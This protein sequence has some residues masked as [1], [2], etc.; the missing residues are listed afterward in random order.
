VGGGPIP[1]YDQPPKP[2]KVTKPRYPAEALAYKVEGTVVVEILIDTEGRVHFRRIV[3]SVP[4]LDVAAAETVEQW[5]FSPAIKNGSPVASVAHAPVGFHLPSS[6]PDPP[7]KAPSPSPAASSPEPLKARMQTSALWFDPEGADFS[8]W[9]KL[10]K[11]EAYRNWKI[12]KES[13]DLRGHVDL[14][15]TVERDGSISSLRL[16][17][18]SAS[19]LLDRAAEDAV[20]ASVLLPLPV[21]FPS[22]RVKMQ[23]TFFYNEGPEPPS[24]AVAPRKP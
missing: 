17:T 22:P 20:R 21:D 11:D 23:T 18:S 4:A 1:D 10:F 13:P 19:P 16:R 12:P 2:I 24:A 15:L 5:V 8:V 14:E 3:K 7:D 6:A 9:I